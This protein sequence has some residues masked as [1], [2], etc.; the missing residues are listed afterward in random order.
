MRPS[1]RK[2]DQLRDIEFIPNYSPYAEGS[3]LVKF[4]N[5]HVLC[6]A[7]VE[8]KLPPF[9]R[10]QGKGWITA[11]YGMLPRSTHQR[12][13]REASRGKQTGRTQE[14][15]RLIGRSLR[16]I[17]NLKAMGERQIK[18]D[19]DVL[20][21]DGGTRTA[22]ITG[23]YVALYLAFKGLVDKKLI[24]EIPL[25]DHVAAISCGVYKDKVVL[26]LDYL[27]DSSAAADS[28]FILT[29]RNQIVEIQTTA[30]DVPFSCETFD[31]MMAMAK[32][33]V[34][35]LVKLQLQ[36]IAKASL[37]QNDDA[38]SRISISNS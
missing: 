18:I 10:D 32:L 17:T 34:S 38:A 14:I 21:A 24:K 31:E 36:A 11:E 4:G 30:E 1:G 9:M 2:P 13:D 35:K 22:A 33:G 29:S 27:E 15:Q 16:A 7:S 8:E 5:T 23:S 20:Q 19:C 3:C 28:N 12:M 6:T 26:D 25:T 37:G